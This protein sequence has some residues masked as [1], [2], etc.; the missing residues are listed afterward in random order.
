LT[1]A[2][3]RSAATE[4]PLSAPELAVIVAKPAEA[5]SKAGKVPFD[6]CFID[7]LNLVDDV[8]TLIDED[9]DRVRRLP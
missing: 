9:D 1:I 7:V 3:L 6:D 5:S 4:S 8:L 2:L